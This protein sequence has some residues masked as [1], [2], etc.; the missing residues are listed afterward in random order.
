MIL[1]YDVSINL[2]F[3]SIEYNISMFV[4]VYLC[5]LL[6]DRNFLFQISLLKIGEFKIW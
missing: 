6:I 4:F 2:V 5:L 1:R 3:K